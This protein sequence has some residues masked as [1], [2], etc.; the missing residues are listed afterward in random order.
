MR[1]N[2][3]LFGRR[4]TPS[5]AASGSSRWL[6][7]CVPARASFQVALKRTFEPAAQSARSPGNR[8]GCAATDALLLAARGP[9]LPVAQQPRE[10]FGGSGLSGSTTSRCRAGP[11]WRSSAP[12]ASMSPS[13]TQTERR[14]RG[15]F[16][17]PRFGAHACRASFSDGGRPVLE[18]H[19]ERNEAHRPAGV[20]RSRAKAWVRR[21]PRRL[22]SAASRRGQVHA[23]WSRLADHARAHPRRSPSSRWLHHLDEEGVQRVS[24]VSS[25]GK[26]SPSIPPSRP[27]TT[28]PSSSPAITSPP[29]ADAAD[30]GR[31]DE[32]GVERHLDA[33]ESRSVSKLST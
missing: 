4:T 18:D 22:L 9:P 23:S 27:A 14:A 13:I 26:R 3:V 19:A 16:R 11:L 10:Q 28:V 8:S 6:S 33:A 2:R 20:R 24:P 5:P 15:R 29:R 21:P 17:C 12:E 32:D 25:G 31:A 7:R 30:P 1:A